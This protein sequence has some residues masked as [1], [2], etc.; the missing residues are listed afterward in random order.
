MLESGDMQPSQMLSWVR[1]GFGPR[2]YNC[3]GT[4]SAQKLGQS[5]LNTSSNIG[6]DKSF[7][8]DLNKERGIVRMRVAFVPRSAEIQPLFWRFVTFIPHPFTTTTLILDLYL[9][10]IAIFFWTAN[11]WGVEWAPA[12]VLVEV[13]SVCTSFDSILRSSLLTGLASIAIRRSWININIS[14][15]EKQEGEKDRRK[16]V[17]ALP[18]CTP[19]SRGRVDRNEMFSRKIRYARLDSYTYQIAE[20]IK[21]D[22][23]E[24]GASTVRMPDLIRLYSASTRFTNWAQVRA[25]RCL[26]F[27]LQPFFRFAFSLL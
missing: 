12:A 15:T 5:R 18:A 25:G 14:V 9:I 19:G 11:R 6:R 23:Y 21:F 17:L 26:T 22:R 8:D 10:R 24:S 27:S 20:S 4:V 1:I 3:R 7:V 13:G 2:S 16:E